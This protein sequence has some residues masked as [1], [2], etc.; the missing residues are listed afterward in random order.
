M[1]SASV[2]RAGCGVRSL[3]TF[4]FDDM[5]CRLLLSVLLAVAAPWAAGADGADEE[6]TDLIRSRNFL[7]APAG[8]QTGTLSSQSNFW[9]AGV[10]STYVEKRHMVKYPSMWGNVSFEAETLNRECF[11]LTVVAGMV[12]SANVAEEGFTDLAGNPFLPEN[13][14]QTLGYAGHALPQALEFVTFGMF[15]LHL[16]KGADVYS[17]QF[18][19]AVGKLG[20]RWWLGS[21]SCT[22]GSYFD[23]RC[24]NKPSLVFSL[25]MD[26]SFSSSF[27][28]AITHECQ[29]VKYS[30]HRRRVCRPACFD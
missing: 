29:S 22:T 6:S 7:G 24:G 17:W 3:S 16:K 8:M 11:N 9:E 30:M 28:A 18:D 10:P 26:S 4:D 27:P 15:A 21:T 25:T 2:R 20:D 14:Y 13:V 23:F 1:P 5:S 12:K 19:M